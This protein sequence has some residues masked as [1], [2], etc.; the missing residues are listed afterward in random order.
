M[1]ESYRWV[2]QFTF[3]EAEV[4]PFLSSGAWDGEDI[5]LEYTPS[6]WT[7]GNCLCVASANTP[8][9][10]LVILDL[11]VVLA[12]RDGATFD[13]GTVRN[14]VN[15]LV[16]DQRVISGGLRTFTFWPNIHV[17]RVR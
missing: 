7:T 5:R 9:P 6:G 16:V 13:L 3:T 10:A 8:L 1:P 15:L 4:E 11:A 2:P 12:K 17:N 14:Y